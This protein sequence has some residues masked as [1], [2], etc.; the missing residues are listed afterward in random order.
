MIR[1]LNPLYTTDQTKEKTDVLKRSFRTG[2]GA[3]GLYLITIASNSQ[4]VFDII[5]IPLLKQRSFRHRDFD[6]IGLAESKEAAFL[7]VQRIYEDYY[8]V[9]S[10]YE[11]I[12]AELEARLE[13]QENQT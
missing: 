9:F 1:Y 11:G 7:L 2:T 10:S 13:E 3:V 6:V 12:R 4:D 5:P 8:R